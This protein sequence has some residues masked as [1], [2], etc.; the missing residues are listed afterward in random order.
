MNGIKSYVN[1]FV[2]K[3]GASF[4]Q[5]PQVASIAKQDFCKLKPVTDT[6]EHSSLK[7]VSVQDVKNLFPKGEIEAENIIREMRKIKRELFFHH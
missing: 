4:V 7:R 6:F 3:A 1:F 2:Q 5:R